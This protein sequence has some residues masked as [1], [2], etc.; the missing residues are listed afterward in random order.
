MPLWSVP[1]SITLLVHH[2][3]AK[4]ATWLGRYS[5][6]GISMLNITSSLAAHSLDLRK[7]CC[8]VCLHASIQTVLGSYNPSIPILS[9]LQPVAMALQVLWLKLLLIVLTFLELTHSTCLSM[10]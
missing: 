6:S 10:L 3:K 2:L 1:V 5:L 7:F 9:S 4:I 8:I